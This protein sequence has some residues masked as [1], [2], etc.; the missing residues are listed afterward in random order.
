MHERV[1]FSGSEL[2]LEQIADHT[3]DVVQALHGYFSPNS[4][5]YPTR[6]AGYLRDEVANDL[7]ERVSESQRS[8]S[9]SLLASLEATFRIDYLNRCQLKE[10]DAVS[11][12]F[13]LLY[14]NKGRRASLEDD[15]L[16][17]WVALHARLKSQVSDIRA[18]FKYRHWLAHGRYWQPKLGRI[19]DYQDVYV[20]ADRAVRSFP[21]L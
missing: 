20:I 3:T 21:F 1:K 7:M 12:A 11:R 18:A 19:H 10:R 6:F 5:T 14:A 4:T 16:G 15:I 2:T 8:A 9:L 13:R 17:A